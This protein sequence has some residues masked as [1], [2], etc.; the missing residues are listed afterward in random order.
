MEANPSLIS[1]LKK[2]DAQDCNY[3]ENK[4]HG[5]V[6]DILFDQVNFENKQ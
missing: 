2:C 5:E 1:I 6:G 3:N 4:H